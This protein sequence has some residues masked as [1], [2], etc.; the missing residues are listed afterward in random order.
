MPEKDSSPSP[1][2]S[3]TQS[4]VQEE[5]KLPLVVQCFINNAVV[6]NTLQM[7][8]SKPLQRLFDTWQRFAV[9]QEWVTPATNLTFRFDGDV[10]KGDETPEELDL[11][12]EE[13]IDVTW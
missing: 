2:V 7:A 11:E 9:G 1:S 8:A 13:V 6:T 10:L 3:P 5:V 12:G 4:P